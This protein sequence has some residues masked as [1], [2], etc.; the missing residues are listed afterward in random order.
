MLVFEPETPETSPTKR[1]L[2]TSMNRYTF[3]NPRC[4]KATQ[5]CPFLRSKEPHDRPKVRQDVK[6]EA[7]GLPNDSFGDRKLQYLFPESA[8][9]HKS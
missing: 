1:N 2:E 7:Q 8:R 3:F 5:K 9:N 6:V 4:P